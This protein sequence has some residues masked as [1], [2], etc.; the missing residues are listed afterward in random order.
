VGNI[1]L[2]IIVGLIAGFLAS[3]V[4]MGKGRGWFWNIVIG[5][6]GAFFGGWLAGLLH[7]S[8]GLGIFGDIV[9]AFAGAVILLLIWRLLFRRKN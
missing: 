2:F 9:I 5:I 8:I 4:V 3:R 6:L 1:L 7:I